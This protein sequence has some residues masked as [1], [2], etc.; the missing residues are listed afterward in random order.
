MRHKLKEYQK[1]EDDAKI[2]KE[3]KDKMLLEE[4]KKK[5]EAAE[6]KKE[7]DE[8]KK[9]AIEEYRQ[10]EAKKKREEEEAEEAFQERMRKTLSQNGVPDYQISKIIKREEKAKKVNT[11]TAIAELSRPTY[12]RVRRKHLEPETLNVYKLP[13]SYDEEDEDFII[14]KQWVPESLQETLFE[15]TRKIRERRQITYTTTELRKD[16]DQLLLIKKKDVKKKSPAR[17]WFWT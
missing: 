10:K 9:K 15:H 17:N 14:I 6:R 11:T 7:D 8:L 13:W 12:I 5:S 1:K 4:A 3:L 16:R 2:A